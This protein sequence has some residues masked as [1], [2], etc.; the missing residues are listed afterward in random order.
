MKTYKMLRRGA[1]RGAVTKKNRVWREGQLIVAPE[2]EFAHLAGD[3]YREATAAEQA[4][5]PRAPE[6]AVLK[7]APAKKRKPASAS[8]EAHAEEAAS[9]AGAESEDDSAE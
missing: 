2:K 7:P 3:N 6:R 5:A 9:E 8:Q 1:T 4:T